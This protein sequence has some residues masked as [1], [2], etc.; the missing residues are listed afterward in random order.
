M[1]PFSWSLGSQTLQPNV[2]L[3][4]MPQN[5]CVFLDTQVIFN[6]SKVNS[7]Q[8]WL[9]RVP[10]PIME[11]VTEFTSSAANDFVKKLHL[12][13]LTN[14]WAST[15]RGYHSFVSKAKHLIRG[16]SWLFVVIRGYSWI[17]VT[18]R[19]YKKSFAFQISFVVIRGYSDFP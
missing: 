2:T 10:R 1:P 9:I 3:K 8:E 12:P 4:L 16:Y 13:S 6:Q 11:A 7:G 17:F 18:I 5:V 15:I 14:T 19:G